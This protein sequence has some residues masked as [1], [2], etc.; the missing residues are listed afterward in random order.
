MR[1]NVLLFVHVV[2]AM[3]LL[4]GIL[5]ATAASVAARRRPPQSKLFLDLTWWASLGSV[6]A[7]VTTVVLG[8]ALAA[9]EDIEAGWLDASRLLAFAGL[10][11]GSI[12]LA[13]L[14]RLALRRPGLAGTV[15][16]VGAVVGAAALATVFVMA[17]KPA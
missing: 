4:G 12:V 7:A 16:A 11:L 14:A 1:S 9:D 10:L 15:A 17:A 2:V 5:A 6:V 8:E 3:V 13:A